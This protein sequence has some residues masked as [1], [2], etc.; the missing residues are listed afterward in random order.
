AGLEGGKECEVRIC[1]SWGRIILK[2]SGDVCAEERLVGRFAATGALELPP[3]PQAGRW[4]LTAKLSCAVRPMAA[5]KTP[6][7]G[8]AKGDADQLGE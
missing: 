2:G 6:R 3:W 4:Y 8:G 5:S 7:G 1:M